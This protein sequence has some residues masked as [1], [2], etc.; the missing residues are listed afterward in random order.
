M[1]VVNLVGASCIAHAVPPSLPIN[2]RMSSTFQAVVRSPSFTGCG[3]LPDLT[4]F[5][6]DVLPTGINGGVGGTAFGFPMICQ[7][8][9]NPASGSWW[10]V[11]VTM[12]LHSYSAY[13]L[14]MV[15]YYLH[16]FAISTWSNLRKLT[17]MTISG[18]FCPNYFFFFC[19][20]P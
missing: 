17:T 18:I 10:V 2:A 20:F 1:C 6:N 11:D 9:K 4:P 5:R 14:N 3:Y 7:S 16:I 8:L 19:L 15:N 13:L 12:L